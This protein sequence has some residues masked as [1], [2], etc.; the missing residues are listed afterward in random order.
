MYNSAESVR[1]DRVNRCF[2]DMVY[3]FRITWYFST[4]QY[5][6]FDYFVADSGSCCAE[7]TCE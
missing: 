3:Y 5:F 2:E 6:V 4:S 1:K 7:T